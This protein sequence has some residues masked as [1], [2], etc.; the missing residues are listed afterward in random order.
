[1]NQHQPIPAARL[2][3]CGMRG[4]VRA[5]NWETCLPVPQ[6]RHVTAMP[7][8]TANQP[9]ILD[10]GGKRS[11]TP[12]SPA[13]ATPRTLLRHWLLG[14]VAVRKDCWMFPHL[15]PRTAPLNSVGRRCPSAPYKI[16]VWPATKPPVF[17]RTDQTGAPLRRQKLG[18]HRSS[19]PT[20]RSIGTT[21][22]PS[23]GSPFKL[24]SRQKP[25]QSCIIKAYQ[26]KR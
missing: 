17:N 5:L 22:N 26:G 18:R 13:P 21:Q 19:S 10:C 25:L 14:V 6:W 12:L 15:S 7:Q 11:A 3:R 23:P 9:A 16:T 1:M 2:P 8:P 4:H 20:N 24:Q